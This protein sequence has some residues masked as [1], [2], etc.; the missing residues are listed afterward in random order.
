MLAAEISPE[1]IHCVECGRELVD[2]E[3]DGSSPTRC[4]D[5]LELGSAI[6]DRLSINLNELRARAGISLN[7]LSARAAMGYSTISEIEGDGAHELRLTTALR[8]VHP[9]GASIDQ[10]TERIYW[11]PGQVVHNSQHPPKE[12][13]SG[14]FLVLPSNMPVFE[15]APPCDPVTTRRSSGRMSA[16][17]ASDGI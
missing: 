4:E 1:P 12:R 7:E 15:P 6:A 2:L 13:L 9:L 11:N 10:L 5:C 3:P 16:A 14:F 8:L 17:L